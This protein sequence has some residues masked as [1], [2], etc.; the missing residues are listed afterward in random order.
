MNVDDWHCDLTALDVALRCTKHLRLAEQQQ[1]EMRNGG[2]VNK[3]SLV[4]SRAGF[5]H[6]RPQRAISDFDVVCMAATGGV[7]IGIMPSCLIL[8]WVSGSASNCFSASCSFSTTGWGAAG[9][10]NICQA[11]ASKPGTSSAIG[12]T[13]AV[14]HASLRRNAKRAHASG[15]N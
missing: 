9:A 12:G 13:P 2:W 11:T 6:T 14:P 7:A 3:D 15:A 8:R 10:T 5:H 1:N 4:G